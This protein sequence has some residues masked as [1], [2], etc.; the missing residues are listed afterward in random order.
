MDVSEQLKLSRLI[1]ITGGMLVD[2]PALIRLGIVMTWVGLKEHCVSPKPA[3]FHELF[4]SR[5]VS[6]IGLLH[7]FFSFPPPKNPDH[8]GGEKRVQQG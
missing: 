7:N 1:S 4:L 3:R 2:V 6:I 5:H 8:C